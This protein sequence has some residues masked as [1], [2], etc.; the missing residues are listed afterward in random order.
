MEFKGTIIITD[1]CYIS[2]DSDWGK[3]FDYESR[4]ISHPCFSNYLWNCTG[5]GDGTWMVAG[6]DKIMSQ[7]EL[8]D[9]A[10]DVFKKQLNYEQH[11]ST[12]NKIDYEKSIK[13]DTILGQFGVDSGTFGVFYLKDVLEYYP[14]FLS[15]LGEWCYTI[16][17]DFVGNIDILPSTGGSNL[18]D[19]RDFVILG[20]GNKTFY[21]RS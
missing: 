6:V 14:S 1:P 10:K 11:Y 16:I 18:E 13:Q 8:E 3:S 19:C 17:P 20:V 9:H 5:I 7:L 12:K 2:K 21:S 4:I 15:D